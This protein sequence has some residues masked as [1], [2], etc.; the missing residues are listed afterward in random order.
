MIIEDQNIRE[1]DTNKTQDFRIYKINKVNIFTDQPANKKE[2]V[3]NDS[4]HYKGYNLYSEKKLKYKPK[5]ITDA[6]F[7]APGSI[8]SDKNTILTSNTLVT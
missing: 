8:Y 6:I 1:N 5:A 4:V 7:F 2:I 3:V